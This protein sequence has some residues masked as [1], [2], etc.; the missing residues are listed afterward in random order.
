M[1]FECRCKGNNAR[2]G[3]CP[4]TR[5]L[6]VTPDHSDMYRIFIPDGVHSIPLLTLGILSTHCTGY[7]EIA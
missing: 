3:V 6:R 4:G 5:Q 7:I 1:T 2:R